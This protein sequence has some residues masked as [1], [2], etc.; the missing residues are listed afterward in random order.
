MILKVCALLFLT[1]L[2]IFP[3]KDCFC[4]TFLIVVNAVRICVQVQHCLEGDMSEG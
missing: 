2:P 1:L 4:G 3:L